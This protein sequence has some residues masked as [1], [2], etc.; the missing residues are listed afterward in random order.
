MIDLIAKLLWNPFLCFFYISVGA[1]F[2]Y[3]TNALAWRKSFKIFAGIFRNDKSKYNDNVISHTKAFLSTIAATTGVGNLAGVGTAIHLGG[4][5]ALFWMWVSALIGMSFRLASTYFAVK[6]RPKDTKSL[7]FATPMT[8]LQ[9]ACTGSWR[10]VTP[11]IAGLIFIQGIVLS[12]LVQANSLAH[13]L[14]KQFNIPKVAIAIVLTIFVAFVILGGLKRIVDYSSAVAP[15]MIL[16][17]VLAGVFI[18]ISDPLRTLNALKEVFTFAFNP[19]SMVGGFTGY[20]VL[21]AMQFGISRGVFSHG[22]GLGRV[23]FCRELMKNPR[24]LE[25]LW[26]R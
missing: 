14:H 18:L 23:L 15:W 4:P 10:F 6:F 1:L 9:K 24:Q 12:N 25:P 17:Y 8:Y 5:G 20:T 11:L 22:S 2:L 13:A 16:F 3:F 21:Q 7:A 26:L 19:V